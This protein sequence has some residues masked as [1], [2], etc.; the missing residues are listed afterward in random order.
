MSD[1]KNNPA[2]NYRGGPHGLGDPDDLSLR[3][4]EENVLIPKLIREVS[5]QEK[6][7]E[8]VQG[9]MLALH[10][11]YNDGPVLCNLQHTFTQCCCD[12]G[13]LMVVKCRNENNLLKECLAKWFTN[14]EFAA[15]CK[16]R[17]LAERSEYRRTGITKKRREYNQSVNSESM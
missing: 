17:Y 11:V 16:Q 13:L 5:R 14:T 15:A 4:V 1:P 9:T 10:R 7:T 8:E 3:K 6:C 2:F 12:S